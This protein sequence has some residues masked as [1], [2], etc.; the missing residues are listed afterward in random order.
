MASFPRTCDFQTQDA[1]TQQCSEERRFNLPSLTD[2]LGRQPS[3]CVACST[4]SFPKLWLI[5]DGNVPVFLL[6][7]RPWFCIA[8]NV[9]L[10]PG[11]VF[12]QPVE[13]VVPPVR[14]ILTVTFLITQFLRCE[15]SRIFLPATVSLEYPFS[16]VIVCGI[17][18]GFCDKGK[19]LFPLTGLF[20]VSLAW[21]ILTVVGSLTVNIFPLVR[22]PVDIY[23]RCYKRKTE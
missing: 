19:V 18:F 6:L 17:G 8:A 15:G 7:K 1:A 21:M 16:V 14:G 9:L 20:A 22:G 2:F 11:T 13:A 23:S 4:K 5:S 3:S 10:D 12:L